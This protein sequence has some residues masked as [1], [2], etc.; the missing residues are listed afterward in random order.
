MCVIPIALTLVMAAV[1]P[2]AD[3]GMS[4]ENVV[5]VVNG[6]SLES[7]TVANHY[8]DLRSIPTRNIVVLDNVPDT[9]SIT[10][11]E[12]KD[13]ILQPLLKTIDERK[14]APQ[15]RV[16]AYSAGFPTAVKIPEHTAE[17]TDETLKKIQQPVASITGLT[18]FYQFVLANQSGYLNLGSNFYARGRFERH[19]ANPFTGEVGKR[20]KEA[21]SLSEK[22]KFADAATA[23]ESLAKE[24]P[25]IPAIAIRAAEAQAQSD[26]LDKAIKSAQTAITNG[27]WSARYLEDS[28]PLKEVI[29]DPQI[30]ATLALLDS[31][32]A[33]WQG[34]EAFDAAAGWTL[35]GSRINAQQ[36]GTRYLCSCALAVVHPRGNTLGQAVRNLRRSSGAD[37]TFPSGRFAFAKNGDVRAKTRFPLIPD[38]VV[39][40]QENKY[41]TELFSNVLPKKPGPLLGLMVGNATVDLFKQSWILVPGAIAENLTSFG[42]KYDIQ[43][44]TKITEFLSAGAAMSSGTVHEPYAIQAKFPTPMLYVYYAAGLSAIE[45]F[46]QSITSPY[47]LLIVGDP[48]CQP[49]AKA[50]ADTMEFDLIDGDKKKLQIRRRSLALKVP[51][52]RTRTIEIYLDEKLV[53]R[54]PPFSTIDINGLDQA[55]GC[56]D[57]RTSLTGL[58]RTKPR[59][60]FAE[61][62]D[63][64]GPNPSPL[65]TV[66]QSRTKAL[67]END[68]GKSETPITFS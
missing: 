28:E 63:F 61:Q 43:G 52:S 34:P 9:L 68:N 7:R 11:D 8:A 38:A 56:L 60:T 25:S 6:E 29:E 64:G 46:Y 51:Q 39:Y 57:I 40:L 48:L 66:V 4:A 47:Q 22:E 44:H 3:A 27:W 12:F 53:K 19:F 36:G 17:L 33:K 67:T 55:T 45:S 15:T 23:W 18:Y 5:V 35:S 2:V 42:G 10:L 54:T 62:I 65:V 1:V 30:K 16:I 50:P 20:F 49:F 41:E 31:S 24:Y 26:Q 13:Q 37:R 21:V 32:A 58:D 14:I 59:I